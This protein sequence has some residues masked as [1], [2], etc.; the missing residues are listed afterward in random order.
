MDRSTSNALSLLE[1][2]Q[3]R[4]MKLISEI[5]NEDDVHIDDLQRRGDAARLTFLNKAQHLDDPHPEPHKQQP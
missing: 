2:I 1:K 3:D 4:S 5:S